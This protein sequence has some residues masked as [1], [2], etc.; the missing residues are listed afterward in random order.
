MVQWIA[1]A[2]DPVGAGRN[3]PFITEMEHSDG[4]ANQC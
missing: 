2:A 4:Y 1:I 3:G